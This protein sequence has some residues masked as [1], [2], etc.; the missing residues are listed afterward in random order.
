MAKTYLKGLPQLKRKLLKL[1]ADTMP[2]VAKAMEKAAQRIVDD[3]KSLVPLQSGDLQDSIG[4]TWGEAPRGSIKFSSVISGQKIT[5]YAGNEKAYYARFVEFGTAPHEI[6]GRFRG[7]QHPGTSPQPFFFSA[8][9]ANRKETKLEIQ[10][11][12][13]AAVREAVK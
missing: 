2:A 5:I 12:I 6:G 9:R 1:K 10:K 7:A 4:W 3:M 8:F 13:R 11:A